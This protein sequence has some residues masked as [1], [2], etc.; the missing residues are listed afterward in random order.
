MLRAHE[1]LAHRSAGGRRIVAISDRLP[2]TADQL[3]WERYNG[4]NLSAD[5]FDLL[6]PSKFACPSPALSAFMTTHDLERPQGDPLTALKRL[7]KCDP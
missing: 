3:E 7:S 2:E 4:Y 6:E 5:H 1:E